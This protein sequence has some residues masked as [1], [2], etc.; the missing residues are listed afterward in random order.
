MKQIFAFFIISGGIGFF[1]LY[2][3]Q[4]TDFLYFGKYNKEE[5]IAWLSIFTVINYLLVSFFI[6][7]VKDV[8]HNLLIIFSIGIQMV[9]FSFIL[10]FLLPICITWSIN[11]VRKLINKPNRTFLPPINSFFQ[12]IK[13]Y[14]LYVYDFDGE[15]VNSGTIIQGTEE[16]QLELSLTLCPI[17]SQM[18]ERKYFNLINKLVDEKEKLAFEEYIDYDKKYH[19]VKVKLREK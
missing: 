15:L 11:A 18:N 2:L 6:A 12:D 1:N 3:A 14:A 8:N 9:M 7:A 19:F 5:R 17:K 4:E 10:S 16:R 13:D